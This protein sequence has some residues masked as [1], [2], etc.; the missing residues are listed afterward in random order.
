MA[1]TK[2]GHKLCIISA[3]LITLY[4]ER[5]LGT[6]RGLSPMTSHCKSINSTIGS[7][8]K[9]QFRCDQQQMTAKS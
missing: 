5:A 3:L 7:A 8:A 9:I 6:Q 1:L 4:S 2:R